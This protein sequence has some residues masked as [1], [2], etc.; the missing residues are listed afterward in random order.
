MIQL[1]ELASKS[2][3]RANPSSYSVG[4]FNDSKKTLT[5]P[6]LYQMNNLLSIIVLLNSKNLY[7]SAAWNAYVKLFLPLRDNY[8]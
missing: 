2:K 6:K 1:E 5:K 7:C 4:G 8:F 3:G